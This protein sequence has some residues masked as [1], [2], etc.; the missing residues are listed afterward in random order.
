M[1]L[2]YAALSFS[3]ACPLSSF[4]ALPGICI[5][6]RHLKNKFGADFDRST[7]RLFVMP[8]SAII[9]AGSWPRRMPAAIAAGYCGEPTVEAFLRRVG[10]EYPQP[11]VKEGRRQLWLRDDLDR[12]IAPDIV[13]GD[14]AE[15]L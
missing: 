3:T 15:D 8:R 1:S 5:I 10:T 11:R 14:L 13:L 9:P 4:Q 6:H 12:A 2:L 7:F